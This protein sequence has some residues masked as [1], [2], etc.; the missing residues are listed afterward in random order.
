MTLQDIFG[1]DAAIEALE[2]AYRADRLPHGLIFAGPAGVG[3]ATTARGLATLF[4]CENPKD[5]KP[6]GKCAS[7]AVMNVLND[8]GTTNHRD[9]PVIYG[10]LTRREKGE[11]KARDLPA[12]VTRDYVVGP[13]G[14]KPMMNLGKV[15]VIREAE[16]MNATA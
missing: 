15:F 6:C 1:Q 3:K 7:C 13:A 11:A 10:Q 8:D 12:S 4:L 9:F 14:R 5:G 16:L 2:R